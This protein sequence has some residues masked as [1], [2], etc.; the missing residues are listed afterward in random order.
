MVSQCQIRVVR[1]G[2]SKLDYRRAVFSADGKYLMCVSGDFIKVYSTATEECI[3]ALQGHHNLVTG[4]ELNPKNHLQLYSCSLDGTIKL[5]D[6]I[7]GILI[8]TFLVG[9]KFISLYASATDELVFAVTL[10]D[11]SRAKSQLVSVKLPKS[12]SQECEAKEIS[13]IFDDVSHFPKCTAVGR[14]CLYVASVKGVHLSIYYFKTKKIYRLSLKATSK[15]GANNIFTVVACHPTEDCIAT[16]HMDGRIRLWRNFN[17][18]QEYTYSSLHWHHDSV[19]D[20]AFSAQGTK[21][22]SGGVE[23]VLVQWPYGSEE[24]KEF[25]PR[26]GAAIEHIAVSPHGTFYCTSH[27]DNKIS[28]IDT[29]LKVSGIIQGLLK[30]TVVRTGLIV[31]P[32]SNGKPGHLQFYSLHNDRHLYNLDIVQQEFIHQAGLQYMD[33]VKAAFSSTGRWLATVEELQGGE[34]SVDLEIQMKLWEYQDKSQSFI[35]NTIISR[36]HEDHITSLCFRDEG[37]SEKEAPTLVTTGKDALFKVWILNNNYDIYKQSSSWCCDFVGSYHKNQATNC[38]FSEDGSLLAV[39]FDEIITV[40]ESNTWDLKQTFCQ[41]PGK[42]RNLCFGRKSCSKY[43]VA[44]TNDGFICCW[45][46]LTCSLE[47]RAQLDAAV[48]QPD[49]LSENIAVISCPKGRSNL[50]LFQPSEPRPFYAQ[51]NIC[52]AAVKWAVFV[53]KEMPEFVKSESHQWLNK[54]QLYFLTEDQDLMTFSSK[55]TEERL[56]P[57]SKQLA[58]EESLPVTPFHLLL[59]KKRQEEREKLGA[60]SV[61]TPPSLH[62]VYQDSAIR[63]VLHTPAHVLPPASVLCAVFVNSLLISK[64]SQSPEESKEDEEMESEHSEVDSSDETEEME[65][66][67]TFPSAFS[68]DVPALLP[69]FQ[70]KELRRIRRTDYS[71]ISSL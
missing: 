38:C 21:L 23:S 59:G 20:L 8:K 66:H 48:L 41:P 1:S 13:V 56:T 53:P 16:G 43:L 12:T 5:W 7:D 9:F 27:T 6:F 18:K 50:F 65:S 60:Q 54:S 69:K 49:P 52:R 47:W 19:M 26:L 32:R 15:K 29:S 24:K 34:D 64:K 3:H 67:K 30:G 11:N 40:W 68:V 36:P 55:S 35:L 44:S 70:E 45:N 28:I 17:H 63:E 10:R 39:S 31:D 4:I 57:L 33:L 61:R 62:R 51:K 2:G 71:W 46:L 22:L 42:I 14:Q 58:V 25:L 37:S